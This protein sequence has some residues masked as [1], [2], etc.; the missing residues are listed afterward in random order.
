MGGYFEETPHYSRLN[1]PLQSVEF[2]TTV[3]G[4][5]PTT[6]GGKIELRRKSLS[7]SKGACKWGV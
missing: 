1:S 5:Y 3:G 4:L 7:T 6:V 2:P